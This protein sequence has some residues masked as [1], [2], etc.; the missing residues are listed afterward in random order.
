[1]ALASATAGARRHLG[2]REP[3]GAVF[4]PDRLVNLLP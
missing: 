1:V 3:R 4:V 2:G